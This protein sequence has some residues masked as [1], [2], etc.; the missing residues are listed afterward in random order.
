[1]H[2]AYAPPRDS[3]EYKVT[4]LGCFEAVM[5]RSAREVAA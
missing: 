2:N 1:M 5:D 4:N 3:P